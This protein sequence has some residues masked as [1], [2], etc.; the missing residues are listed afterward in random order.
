MAR[1]SGLGWEGVYRLYLMYKMYF[2]MFLHHRYSCLYFYVLAILYYYGMTLSIILEFSTQHAVSSH[3]YRT[4]TSMIWR[5]Y[6]NA[7]SRRQQGSHSRQHARG[8]PIRP[9]DCSSWRASSPS[10]TCQSA[11]VLALTA[12]SLRSHPLLR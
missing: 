12:K 3:L 2:T 7:K 5:S 10:S 8:V 9:P 1:V 6:S 4:A 11:L